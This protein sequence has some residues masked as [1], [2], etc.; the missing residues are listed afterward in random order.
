MIAAE[1]LAPTQNGFSTAVASTL[2]YTDF[3]SYVVDTLASSTT[4]SISREQ[5]VKAWNRGDIKAEIKLDT[6]SSSEPSMQLY[7][8]TNDADSRIISVQELD[9]PSITQQP[10][11]NSPFAGDFGLL[12]RAA[13]FHKY[14]SIDP[15]TVSQFADLYNTLTRNKEN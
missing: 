5:A 13:Y 1:T 8:K 15:V 6:T 10:K 4:L 9:W 12:G 2:G 3:N 11:W 14:R 7:L